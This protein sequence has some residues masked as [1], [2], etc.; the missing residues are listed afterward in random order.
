MGASSEHSTRLDE[1][2][3][4]MVESRH[5]FLGNGDCR[6]IEVGAN[7]SSIARSHFRAVATVILYCSDSPAKAVLEA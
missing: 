7:P 4:K 3:P 5:W 2:L 6:G 1:M